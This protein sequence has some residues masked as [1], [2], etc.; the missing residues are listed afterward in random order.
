MTEKIFIT[1]VVVLAAIALFRSVRKILKGGCSC[2]NGGC[3]CR[4]KGQQCQCEK[5]RHSH[6][7]KH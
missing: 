3:C 6:E 2:G 7:H 1:V 4:E 5:E